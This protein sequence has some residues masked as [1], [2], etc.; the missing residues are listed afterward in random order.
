MKEQALSRF[1]FEEEFKEKLVELVVYKNV[2][3][4]QVAKKYRL[5]NITIL[6][7]WITIKNED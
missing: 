3:A 4:E 6:I 2:S 1:E 5:P 7:N